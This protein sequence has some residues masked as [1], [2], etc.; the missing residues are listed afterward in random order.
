M[1]RPIVTRTTRPPNAA[2]TSAYAI[3]WSAMLH[4]G[5]AHMIANVHRQSSSNVLVIEQRDEAGTQI[6]QR[7]CPRHLEQPRSAPV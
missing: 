1:H 3:S 5:A 2:A 4:H 7:A 6:L